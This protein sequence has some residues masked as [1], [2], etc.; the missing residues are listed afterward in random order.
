[1]KKHTI[2]AK[3]LIAMLCFAMLFSGCKGKDNGGGG[4]ENP[5]NPE[6]VLGDSLDKTF[7]D[8]PVSVLEEALK[9][10]K[11][12]IS[13]RDDFENILY[14]DSENGDLVD[15]LKAVIQGVDLNLSIFGN[16]NRIAVSLPDILDDKAY[17]I[18][19]STLADDLASTPIW[20][21]VGVSYEDVLENMGA[22]DLDIG[23]LVE[24]GGTY[25]EIMMSLEDAIDEALSI[26]ESSTTEGTVSI[27]GKD[28]KATIVTFKIDDND[29]IEMGKVFVDWA[30]TT[31]NDCANELKDIFEGTD[32]ADALEM[33][34]PFDDA[35]A[36]IEK[37]FDE[38]DF[39]LEIVTN[40]NADSGLLMSV[41][42]DLVV[43]YAGDD[44]EYTA[45][46]DLVLG[47]DPK[48]SNLYSLKMG[49]VNPD[50]EEI[51][52]EAEL[53][54]NL[55]DA[56]DEYGIKV[57]VF[58]DDDRDTVLTGNLSYNKSS[59]AYVL[60]G[61]AG[62]NELEVTGKYQS[63]D[64]YFELSVDE[65]AFN[66]DSVEVGIT[67]RVEDIE[68]SE[69]PTM[70]TFKNILKMSRDEIME[71]AQTAMENLQ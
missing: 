33:D 4:N 25:T 57:E 26:P 39:T 15:E 10:G 23:Q 45:Y 5:T 64:D 49:A 13:Y 20:D 54:R 65:V 17:G 28:V 24:L 2:F 31:Y 50:D 16:E 36:E 14:L 48:N 27:N 35:R 55:S 30:E 8:G 56:K 21:I 60:S 44:E 22:S 52:L 47:E 63:N 9:C 68:R 32:V 62:G 51:G 34:I 41:D 29:L 66:G 67:V 43:K 7:G 53:T 42:G 59:H 46:L 11:I 69:I 1:M 12:T 71:L 18:D 37:A 3:L 40:I 38:V 61:E 58:E 6:S 70:P 19:F